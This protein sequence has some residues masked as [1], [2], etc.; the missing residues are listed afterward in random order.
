MTEL[1]LYH[2]SELDLYQNVVITLLYVVKKRISSCI[3]NVEGRVGI[4]FLQNTLQLVLH[5]KET[6]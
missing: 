3:F 1:Y 6:L 2:L 5:L 4:K